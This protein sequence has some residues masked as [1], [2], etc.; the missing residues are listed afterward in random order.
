MPDAD[1]DEDGVLNYNDAFPL[2]PLKST[3]ADYDGVDDA[4]DTEVLQS[5]LLVPEYP[6]EMLR[7]SLEGTLDF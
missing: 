3:D 6:E 7:E 4:E 2:D 1:E 5:S